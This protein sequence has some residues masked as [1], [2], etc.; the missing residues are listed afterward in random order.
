MMESIAVTVVIYLFL[1]WF[2]VPCF[3]STCSSLSYLESVKTAHILVGIIGIMSG[4]FALLC[5]STGVLLK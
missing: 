5:W 2:I 4:V 1:V 3:S